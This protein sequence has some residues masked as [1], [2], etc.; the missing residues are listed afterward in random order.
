MVEILSNAKVSQIID[1]QFANE[2][3][4]H[5]YYIVHH[6]VLHQPPHLSACLLKTVCKGNALKREQWIPSTRTKY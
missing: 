5:H 4:D 2:I 6:L 3:Q 1:P